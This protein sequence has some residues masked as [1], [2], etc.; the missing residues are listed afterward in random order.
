MISETSRVEWTDIWDRPWTQ[1]IRSIFADAAP[2]PGPLR[3]FQMTTTFELLEPSTGK[4]SL[5]WQSDENMIVRAQVKVLNNYEKWFEFTDCQANQ[6]MQLGV[7]YAGTVYE[8]T[9]VSSNVT[10]LTSLTQVDRPPN[11]KT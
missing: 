1:P 11:L 3:N 8:A 10:D 6:V 5:H 7:P 9:T 2:I 4:R